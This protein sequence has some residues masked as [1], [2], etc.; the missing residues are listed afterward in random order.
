M[1]EQVWGK[2][3]YFSDPDGDAVSVAAPSAYTIIAI[4]VGAAATVL[5]GVVPSVLLDLADRSALFLP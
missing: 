1:D 2:F 3:V 4:G 5:L